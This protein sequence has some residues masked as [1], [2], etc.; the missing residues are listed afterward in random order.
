MN[1]RIGTIQIL[2]G[3]AAVL[4]VLYH[5][6]L[7]EK[8]YAAGAFLL[9]DLLAYGAC[10]VDMFFLI[11][12][13]VLMVRHA[14][15]AGS[16]TAAGAFLVRRLLRIYP[17]YWVYSAVM[18]AVAALRPDLVDAAVY[19]GVDVLQSFLLLPQGGAPLLSVAW[20]L[21]HLI[22]FS[23]VFALLLAAGRRAVVPGLCAWALLIAA[24]YAWR[25]GSPAL[26]A[27]PWTHL[28]WHPLTLEFILG[29]ALA[30]LA[31]RTRAGARTA[32][33]GGVCLLGGACLA[34][35][36]GHG[37]VLPRNWWRVLVFGIPCACILYGSVAGAP[38]PPRAV[39]RAL[40]VFGDA[41]YSL[42]LS[43]TLVLSAVGRVWRVYPTRHPAAQAAW[44]GCMFA[45]ALICGLLS[46]RLLEQP[47]GRL[48]RMSAGRLRPGC[49]R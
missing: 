1:G 49:S 27:M 31:R 39:G 44:L 25:G 23:F 22:Y 14:D 41:S 45:A 5:L 40:H 47:L 15:R 34:W 10:G 36:A 28:V 30:L 42:Y 48:G 24:G 6:L 2:R 17:L 18:L 35:Y 38:A 9:P 33:I 26:R 20:A 7:A 29:C 16:R 37:T 21:T 3:A 12:G 4:I 46:Y 8:T 13:Y 19:A 11:S 32:W 43:H